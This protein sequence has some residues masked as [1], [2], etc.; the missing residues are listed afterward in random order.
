MKVDGTNMSMIRGDSETITV[1]CYDTDGIQISLVSGDTI[2]FTVKESEYETT[3]I[4]Q[5]VITTFTDGKAIIILDPADTKS[6]KFKTYKYDIQLTNED[7]TVTTIIPVSN[8]V[9]KAEVT[10]D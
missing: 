7:G 3:K 1:T 6:I 5:K 10:Y 8:F 9:I 2:Y 4:L